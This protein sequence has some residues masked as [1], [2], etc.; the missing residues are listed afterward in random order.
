MKQT[1]HTIFRGY[2]SFLKNAV[3]FTGVLLFFLLLACLAG[4]PMWYLATKH[5]S[6]YTMFALGFLILAGISSLFFK[7]KS[8]YTQKGKE[9]ITAIV[10]SVSVKTGKTVFLIAGCTGIAYLFGH[11]MIILGVA[12]VILLLLTVGFVFF[13]K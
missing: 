3:S 6:T 13:R 12:G 4:Y 5:S 8:T 7:L 1:V 10:T 11:G 9:G 2:T